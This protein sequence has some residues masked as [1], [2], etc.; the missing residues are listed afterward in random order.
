MIQ[1]LYP[2]FKVKPEEMTNTINA[3]H[4][5]LEEYPA[6]AVGA[7]LKIYSKMNASAFPPS[8]SQIICSIYAP[9]QN[10]ELT[11]GEAWALVKRAI[12]KGNYEAKEMFESLPLTVQ[13]AVGNYRMIQEWAATDSDT[14]NTVIMSNFQRSYRAALSKGDFNAR[15]PQE[16][17]DKITT[18]GVKG[19]EG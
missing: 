15:V 19:I 17:K 10:D 4:M 14:V 18:S 8:V 16:I 13:K 5:M 1:A 3:W 7:A 11:E 2:N 6:D 9:K 12:C